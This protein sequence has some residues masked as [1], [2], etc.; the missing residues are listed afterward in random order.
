MLRIVE[1]WVAYGEPNLK[2]VRELIYKRGYGKVDRQRIPL[3]SS[4]VT[5]YTFLLLISL[6]DRQ[7]YH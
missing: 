3:V 7:L 4:N 6:S 5:S 2:S 1:P